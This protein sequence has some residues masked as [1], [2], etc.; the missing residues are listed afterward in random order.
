MSFGRRVCGQSH[1]WSN[2]STALFF[3]KLYDFDFYS[4]DSVIR[5]HGSRLQPS[6]RLFASLN[7]NW[8]MLVTTDKKLYMSRG[9]NNVSFGV[10]ELSSYSHNCSE[11]YFL[12]VAFESYSLRLYMYNWEFID[13]YSNA[14]NVC[15]KI[16]ATA[17][18][19]EWDI[20]LLT[21]GLYN[22]FA[23]LG[24]EKYSFFFGDDCFKKASRTAGIEL[25]ERCTKSGNVFISTEATY[26]LMKLYLEVED[27][28][29]KSLEYAIKLEKKFPNNIIFGY[30]HLNILLT[31]RRDALAKDVYARL[32]LKTKNNNQLDAEQKSHLQ[33]IIRKK[34]KER[35]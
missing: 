20:G 12:G 2:Q 25:L 8:W 33:E 34:Y 7:Y 29:E 11:N 26:F 4:A 5:N 3:N 22:Y 19:Q 14:K 23:A 17:H 28:P 9:F 10:S 24:S 6:L 16:E 15:K 31:L 30:Y 32:M 35:L 27:K 21:L 1:S 13:A 18:C